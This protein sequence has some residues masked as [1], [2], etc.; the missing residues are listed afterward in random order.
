MKSAGPITRVFSACA[1][2]LAFVTMA[3]AQDGRHLTTPKE[4]LGFDIGDDYQLATYTQLDSL[5]EEARHRIRPHA[6]G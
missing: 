1:I 4:A 2:A 3:P 6:A 5:V